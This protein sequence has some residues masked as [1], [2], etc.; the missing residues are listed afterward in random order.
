MLFDKPVRTLKKIGG[1]ANYVRGGDVNQY[2]TKKLFLVQD[3]TC[4]IIIIGMTGYT[5][6]AITQMPQTIPIHLT[7]GTVDGWGSKWI[8]LL[9]PGII[10]ITYILSVLFRNYLKKRNHSIVVTSWI[11]LG[12]VILFAVVNIV[13]I[14]FV[15]G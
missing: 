12:C 10:I 3:I 15:L 5:L 8:S 1:I 11:K 2:A 13:F 14:Q 9:M 4:M 7:D 6:Y